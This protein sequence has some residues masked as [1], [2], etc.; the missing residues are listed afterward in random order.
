MIAMTFDSDIRQ[1]VV[2]IRLYLLY[3]TCVASNSIGEE[4][5][6]FSTRSLIIFF[7]TRL[8]FLVLRGTDETEGGTRRYERRGHRRNYV[9]NSVF[10]FGS[11]R[12]R[13]V[14]IGA[15]VTAAAE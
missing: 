1:S 2:Y 4:F 10:P 5:Q 7:L 15:S 3:H 9:H 13:Q 6:I 8:Y 14:R 12:G 11:S